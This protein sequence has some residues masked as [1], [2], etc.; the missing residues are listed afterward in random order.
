MAKDTMQADHSG[1]SS[2]HVIHH[3]EVPSDM[4]VHE[5]RAHLSQGT[6]ANKGSITGT[7]L[8]G[9]LLFLESHKLS[10]SRFSPGLF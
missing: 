7:K 1:I 8:L 4:R 10:K 5:S 9:R 2:R 6:S 3:A